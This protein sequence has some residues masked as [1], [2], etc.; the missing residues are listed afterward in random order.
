MTTNLHDI[1]PLYV[2]SQEF[3]QNPYPF[4]ETLRSIHP[5]YKGSLLKYHGWFITGYEEVVAVLKDT[6]FQSRFPLPE[7]S[8]KYEQLKNIQSG[9]ML[10]K[11]Q[12]DH[13]R[14]RLLVSQ[15]FTR[16][17]VERCRPFI[18]ET[19]NDL[20]KQVYDNKKMDVVSDFAFPL[21]SLVIAKI[22]GVPEEDRYQF[23][24][25]TA[26][27]IQTI[28]FTRSRKTLAN[29]TE[30]TRKVL[31]YFKELIEK[32]REEPQDDLISRLIQEEQQGDKLSYDELLAACILLMIAGH[33]TTVNLISNSILSLLQNPEQLKK[34]R[35]QP[36][37]IETAVEEFLR[38]ESPAQLIART[39]S[40]N[41][42]VGETTIQKGEQVYLL[43]GAANRDSKKFMNAHMLDITRSP[44]P[45]LAFGYGVHF[46]LGSSL[47]RTEAQI[48]IQALVQNTTN[49]QLSSSNLH[50]RQLIGFRSL[51][52][53]PVT[54]D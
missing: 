11:N 52:E 34:L 36:H 46:C 29:G 45:H 14:L 35:S 6:R 47:A 24:E 9:M 30:I 32:R 7:A 2:A 44:N 40:E 28:D 10:F 3:L 27:F 51:A 8:K 1:P 25:W 13:K 12:Q 54:F 26:A 23:K 15:A 21:A 18:Q 22:L 20:L 5:V 48:A 38:F 33:E 49:L 50:Y 39:A 31:I 53:L 37:L 16:K 19:V 17:T 4:Y 42:A 43:L 41:I